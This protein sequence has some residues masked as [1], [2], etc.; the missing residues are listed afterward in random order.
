MKEVA[1][2][3]IPKL[4][5]FKRKIIDS[6]ISNTL[7]INRKCTGRRVYDE[8]EDAWYALHGS[9][10]LFFITLIFVLLSSYPLE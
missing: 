7:N 4:M 8:L 3:Y 6:D 9:S 10:W 2:F 5:I 1:V